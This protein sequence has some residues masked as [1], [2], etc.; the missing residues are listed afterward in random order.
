MVTV[1]MLHHIIKKLRKK[2]LKFKQNITEILNSI[3]LLFSATV[4]V[5]LAAINNYF[6]LRPILYF[7]HL[8]QATQHVLALSLE[9]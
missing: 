7:L 6:P 5:A 3:I 4:H 9:E 2:T 1:D 8:Q